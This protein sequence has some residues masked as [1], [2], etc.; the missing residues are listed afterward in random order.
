V[1]VWVA[2]QRRKFSNTL[3]AMCIHFAMFGS[4]FLLSAAVQQKPVLQTLQRGYTC[5]D[6]GT[7]EIPVHF[8]DLVAD[9]V[10]LCMQERGVRVVTWDRWCKINKTELE[11]G[12]LVGKHRSKLSTIPELL[13]AA[14]L[15]ANVETPRGS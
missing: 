4:C 12:K 13:S 15:P 1:C 7:D 5:L 2:A 14:D 3:D 10:A 8:H 11:A 9:S 6:F